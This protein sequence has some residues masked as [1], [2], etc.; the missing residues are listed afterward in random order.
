M[1]GHGNWVNATSLPI[2]VS[3][4]QHLQPGPCEQ[5]NCREATRGVVETQRKQWRSK[6]Y[7]LQGSNIYGRPYSCSRNTIATRNCQLAPLYSATEH[8][9]LKKG[10]L[11]Y[12]S[13]CAFKLHFN[14]YLYIYIYMYVCMYVSANYTFLSQGTNLSTCAD[15]S[16]VDSATAC[17]LYH[18]THNV[19]SMYILFNICQQFYYCLYQ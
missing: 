4:S 3:Q 16:R 1:Q 12:T 8:K 14:I 5:V 18:C 10:N 7:C 11:Y 2:A 13:F 15:R 9:Q 17:S 19:N 6:R